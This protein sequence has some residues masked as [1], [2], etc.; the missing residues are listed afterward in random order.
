[1]LKY[2]KRCCVGIALFMW[3]ACATAQTDETV[4]VS[5]QLPPTYI[6]DV[7]PT[8]IWKGFRVVWAGVQDKRGDVALGI[9]TKGKKQTTVIAD[10][11]LE[12]YV[13]DSLQK[14]LM[15]C[16]ME[17][18]PSIEANQLPQL[19][20]DIELFYTGVQKKIFT[21]KSTA[22]SHIVFHSTK[23]SGATG[24]AEVTY[25]LSNKRTSTR[26]IKQL[27]QTLNELLMETLRASAT[28]SDL[29]TILE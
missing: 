28:L 5:L 29:R 17:L 11:P 27:T 8:P 7:C 19:S 3:F 6:S 1:M 2:R 15:A 10:Q 16:G 9:Q 18:A 20:A 14:L 21:G 24:K 25:T 22:S 26:N 12:N 13:N 4:R 23:P